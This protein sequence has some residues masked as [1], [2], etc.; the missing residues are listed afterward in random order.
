ML[1]DLAGVYCV[2]TLKPYH[3]MRLRY[4]IANFYNVQTLTSP[5]SITLVK[6]KNLNLSILSLF[7]FH[8]A[9]TIGV[10]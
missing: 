6:K 3:S 4:C 5:P 7:V 8:M 9:I 2:Q 1:R 10:V